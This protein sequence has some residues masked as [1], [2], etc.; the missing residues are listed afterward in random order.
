MH[1]LIEKLD[2]PKQD[3]LSLERALVQFAFETCSHAVCAIEKID[4]FTLRR[5]LIINIADI[6][7]KN[8]Y[9]SAD[10]AVA[11]GA[12][13]L[14]EWSNGVAIKCWISFDNTPVLHHPSTP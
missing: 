3:M 12:G 13:V 7:A 5:Q 11:T 9:P 1:H 2:K 14:D 8:S 6:E 4:S 10:F